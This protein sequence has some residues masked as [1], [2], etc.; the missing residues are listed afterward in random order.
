MNTRTTRITTPSGALRLT[1]IAAAILAM[2]PLGV[3]H[4]FQFD[5][6]NEDLE[7][8]WDNTVRYNLA[9][10]VNSQN[11]ALLKSPNNDDGNRNF[12]KGIVSNR[13][14]V[15]SEFDVVYQKRYGF[16]LSAAGWYD[17]ALVRQR[18]WFARQQQPCNFQPHG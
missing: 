12:D 13:L 18:V 6:G 2:A 11:D 1:T 9:D 10:R 8:R 14:D 5:T 4:T 16:R 3:A 7:V 17:N 15:L